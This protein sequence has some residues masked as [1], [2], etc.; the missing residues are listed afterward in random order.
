MDMSWIETSLTRL[1][2]RLRSL[3]EGDSVRRDGISQQLNRRL[4]HEL[5]MAMKSGVRKLPEEDVAGS[6]TLIAPDQY[7]LL[8]PAAQAQLLL[9]HPAVLDRLTHKLE[10]TA[11]QQ[12]I[13][14]SVAP[15][16]RVVADPLSA[17]VNVLVEYSHA[18]M[19][20]SRTSRLEG[21]SSPASTD[22]IPQAFLIVNGLTTFPLTESVVNIGRDQSNQLHLD[23]LRISRMHAQL[24]LIQGRFVIFDLDSKGGT[25]VNGVAVS[26]QAL[27]PGDVILLAGVPLVFGLEAATPAGYTQELPVDP[28]VPEVL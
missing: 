21:G 26:S 5:I 6:R 22:G 1:E 24:R 15:M 8:L 4:E 7:T 17:E 16:L 18:G 25:F 14:F 19:G 11:Y 28:P 20:D 3:I 9:T 2:A 12:G 23:D 27:N 13:G 10:N